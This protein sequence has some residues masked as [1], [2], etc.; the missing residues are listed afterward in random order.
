MNHFYKTCEGAKEGKNG[1]GYIEVPWWKVPGRDE[2][3]RIETLSGMDFDMQKF[4]QEFECEFQGSS[5]T[6]I[7]GSKLK[8]LVIKEPISSANDINAYEEPKPGHVYTS[9]VDVSRGRGLDYS[10]LQ[11]I[12][13]TQMPYKQVLTYRNNL[14]TPLDYAEIIFR[15][16]KAYNEAVVL[17][18]IN[19]IGQQVA[20]AIQY[21]Y[22][23][24][25]ILYTQNNGRSG[26]IISS[27]GKTAEV[28]IRTTKSVKSVGCSVLKML[29]EQD[30][31]LLNDYHTINELS[32]FSRKGLSYE[33]ETGSH[34]DMVMCLVL[35][36]WLSDQKYFRE[37]TDINTLAKLREKS[38][39]DMESD[40]LPLG[41]LN[42]G[43]DEPD[44][45]DVVD[46]HWI[47]F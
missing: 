40:M 16:S 20:E 36:A 25:N 45:I 8:S 29:V 4:A 15:L 33:A 44:V 23:Y 37:M 19:D 38:E 5:G 10:A 11:I 28:G 6:L 46:Q 26:K 9:I 21:D 1:Y 43:H 27:G 47:K 30:Q 18:E 3:W 34:D 22:E 17:V 13:T 35:F 42:T 41:F 12:D 24:E 2:A 7:S 31:L 39:E 32:T 14:V